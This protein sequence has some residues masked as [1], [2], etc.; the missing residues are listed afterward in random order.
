MNMHGSVSSVYVLGSGGGTWKGAERNGHTLQ[1]C[2]PILPL[3]TVCPT[4]SRYL[5]LLTIKMR[6]P[7]M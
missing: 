5:R 7:Y 1:N 6:A 3:A 2:L 4:Y